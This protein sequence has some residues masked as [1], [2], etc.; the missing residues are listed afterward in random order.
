MMWAPMPEPELP[1]K[2]PWLRLPEWRAKYE[3]WERFLFLCAAVGA[4]ALLLRGRDG[5]RLVALVALALAA[6]TV[7]FAYVHPMPTQRYLAEVFPLPL[8]LSGYGVA[9]VLSAPWFAARALIARR[10][11]P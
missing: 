6:R 7:M 8:A 1:V 3:R 11:S 10:G 9:A 4:L 5:R 2:V